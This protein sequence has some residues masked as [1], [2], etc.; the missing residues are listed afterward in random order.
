MYLDVT[1]QG[2]YTLSVLLLLIDYARYEAA[3]AKYIPL[4]P[5]FIPGYACV[6]EGHRLDPLKPCAA[7]GPDLLSGGVL[8]N[9]KMNTYTQRGGGF[10]I[11]LEYLA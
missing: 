11:V 7:P 5:Y 3:I 8:M 4:K 10:A 6:S 2:N 9:H 1:Q